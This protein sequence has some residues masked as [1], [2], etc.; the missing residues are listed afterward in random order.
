MSNLEF[1]EFLRKRGVVHVESL[2]GENKYIV[3]D[4]DG[5]YCAAIKFDEEGNLV[6]D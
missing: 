1:L 2:V 6:N 5:W 4:S 3:W